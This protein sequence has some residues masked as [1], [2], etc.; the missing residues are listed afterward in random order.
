MTR[1]KED[2]FKRRNKQFRSVVNVPGEIR[3]AIVSCN[4]RTIWDTADHANGCDTRYNISQLQMLASGKTFFA[5][6]GEAGYPGAI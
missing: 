4:D 5:G 2:D 6:V 3:R 1:C